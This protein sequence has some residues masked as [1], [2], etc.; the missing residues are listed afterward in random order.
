MA[1]IVGDEGF[2][3][4]AFACAVGAMAR[5]KPREVARAMD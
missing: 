5:L 2:V 4:F 1:E 3:I